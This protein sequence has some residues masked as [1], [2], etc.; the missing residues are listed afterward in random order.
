MERISFISSIITIGGEPGVGKSHLLRSVQESLTRNGWTCIQCKFDRQSQN[1]S[2]SVVSMAFDNFFQHIAL[3]KSRLDNGEHLDS[4]EDLL[5][6]IMSIEDHLNATGIVT[7]SAMIPSFR[8]IFPDLFTR[9]VEDDDDVISIESS[10]DGSPD[11][12][13]NGENSDSANNDEED[14]L[15]AHTFKSRFH[16]LFT[17]LVHSISNPENPMLFVL[18]DLQWADRASLDLISSLVMSNR[19]LQ[20]MGDG[21][22]DSPHCLVVAGTYRSDEIDTNEVFGN[23]LR[24][25][26]VRVTNIDLAG[27]DIAGTN[28]ML[29]YT[30]QLPLRLI[31]ELACVVHAKTLGNPLFVKEFMNSLVSDKELQYSLVEARWIWDID[32][33]KSKSVDVSVAEIMTRKV[34]H[35]PKEYQYALS[36]ASCFGMRVGEEILQLL[37]TSKTFIGLVHSLDQIVMKEGMIQ[38]NGSS[39]VFQH[40]LIQ[41]AVYNLIDSKERD[42]LHYNIGV[43]LL[44]SIITSTDYSVDRTSLLAI[45]QINVASSIVTEASLRSPLALL[46]LSASQHMIELAKP[47]SALLYVRHGLRHLGQEGWVS[48]FDVCLRLHDAGCLSSYLNGMPRGV[49][50]YI[51]EIMKH[52]TDMM[53]RM[54]SIYVLI[55]T[56]GTSGRQEV[57]VEKAFHFL[58]L[59]GEDFPDDVSLTD[60]QSALASTKT[61]LAKYSHDQIL[62]SLPRLTDEKKHWAMVILAVFL[63]YVYTVCP[64]YIPLIACI[65]VDTSLASGLCRESASGFF[66]VGVVSIGYFGEVEYGYQLSKLSLSI[67]Q[68]FN[69]R[70][71]YPKMKCLMNG[72]V[73]FWVEPLQSTA[74][75]LA[76]SYEEALMVGDVEYA[77]IGSTVSCMQNIVCGRELFA[78]EKEM[79]ALATQMAQMNQT[80]NLFGLISMHKAVCTLTGTQKDP[81]RAS[82]IPMKDED[83]VVSKF[84][85]ERPSLVQLIYFHQIFVAIFCSKYEVVLKLSSE[86]Q[87][88]SQRK[89][90]IHDIFVVFFQGLSSLRLYRLQQNTPELYSMG[91]SVLRQFQS[92]VTHSEWNFENKLLLLEAEVHFSKGEHDLAEEKYLAAIE[93]ARKHRFV[94]EEGLSNELLSTFYKSR[95]EDKKGQEFMMNAIL[96]YRKWGAFGLLAQPRF[97]DFNVG[98]D[99]K[100]I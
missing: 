74:M 13:Q 77:M 41:Q 37:E 8:A 14:C 7:L 26:T 15:E 89:A 87:S 34:L 82:R 39:F 75:S 47:V 64:N 70:S 91:M 32:A 69:A 62:T 1:Q 21:A 67:L 73:S 16:Y 36:V 24:S 5:D 55:R 25:D 46:N 38:K 30:L 45:D 59:L 98:K 23:L 27:M 71:L 50:A 54:K 100:P 96:C 85:S 90:T 3:L 86:Y 51:E 99:V 72:Y 63:P 11:I 84:A 88:I 92:W 53:G 28:A 9:V 79:D 52:T 49:E 58:G 68:L 81:F 43:E 29:S 18:D 48:N 42:E 95:R 76:E 80:Y 31:R 60:I 56:L 12:G 44:K 94:H 22:D 20:L 66:H 40:D 97:Q 33:V 4:E 78:M 61:K 57:A 10:D 6:M 2:C 65:M 35:M 83:E 93:S 19:Q 17:K